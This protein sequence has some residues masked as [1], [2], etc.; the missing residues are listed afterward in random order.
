[1][2]WHGILM[3][4]RTTVTACNCDG[5]SFDDSFNTHF[6]VGES[7]IAICQLNMSEKC[8][9]TLEDFKTIITAFILEKH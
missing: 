2:A 6:N 7:L 4:K 5:G 1:M 9:G 3:S 8:S